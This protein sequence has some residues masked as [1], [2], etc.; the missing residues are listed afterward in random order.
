MHI[1]N[2]KPLA[3]GVAGTALTLFFLTRFL[4]GG[5]ARLGLAPSPLFGDAQKRLI[6]PFGYRPLSSLWNAQQTAAAQAIP[7]PS[8]SE[9]SQVYN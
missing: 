8:T 9:W 4:P 2:W 3:I 6:E 1:P 5:A 7:K